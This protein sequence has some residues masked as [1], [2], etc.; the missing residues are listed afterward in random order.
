M[1]S[2]L[3]LRALIDYIINMSKMRATVSANHLF[4]DGVEA[5]V[6]DC[7]YTV[8]LDR[9]V[10]TRPFG[11]RVI[12]CSRAEKVVFATDAPI[13]ALV[14]AIIVLAEGWFSRFIPAYRELIRLEVNPSI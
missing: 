10:K 9:C 3:S 12:F 6:L 11:T 8:N 13:D 4:P 7:L 5:F 1:S 2:L 14:L